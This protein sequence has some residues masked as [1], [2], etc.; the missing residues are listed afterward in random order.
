MSAIVFKKVAKNF[1]EN[2]AS[3]KQIFKSQ[4]RDISIA[5]HLIQKQFQL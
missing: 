1:E 4:E 2:P 3:L 5:N